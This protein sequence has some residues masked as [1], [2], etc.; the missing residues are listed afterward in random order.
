MS[1]TSIATPVALIEEII[2]S[3]FNEGHIAHKNPPLLAEIASRFIEEK[4][5][6]RS[7]ADLAADRIAHNHLAYLMAEE[8]ERLNEALID[9]YAELA[10]YIFR[11]LATK[12]A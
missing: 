11:S 5:A 7:L 3:G 6:D 9:Q 2:L 4:T 12:E 10:E 1:V 8:S